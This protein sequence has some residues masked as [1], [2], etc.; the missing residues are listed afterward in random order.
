MPGLNIQNLI[1]SACPAEEAP[2]PDFDWEAKAVVLGGGVMIWLAFGAILPMLPQ[3]DAALSHGP[4]DSLLVKQLFGIVGLSIVIGA[5]LAGFLVDRVGVRVIVVSATLIFCIAGTAG[6]YVN[7]LPL[8]VVSRVLVGASAAAIDTTGITLINACLDGND[9]AKWNG[10]RISFIMASSMLLQPLV[11]AIAEFGW[12]APFALYAVGLPIGLAGALGL[13]K[14]RLVR[15]RVAAAIDETKLWSWF[16]VRYAVLALVLGIC[17]Y[18]P[19]VYGPFLIRETGHSSPVTISLVLMGNSIVGA[20]TAL[21]YGRSRRHLSIDGAFIFCLAWCSA[22][23]LIAA[24]APGFTVL[25]AGFFIGFLGF[26]GISPNLMTAVGESVTRDK[27]GR[28]V[29]LVRSMHELGAPI[30]IVLVQPIATKFGSRGV[31]MTSSL[32][33]LSVLAALVFKIVPRARS[34]Q[35]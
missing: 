3:I 35:H 30:C 13:Q 12:R 25:V 33:A 22:G 2:R 16:P 34:K 11:G 15:E 18:L 9:R 28:A 23:M 6:L 29:G 26:G 17:A 21:L 19:V 1:D 24:L 4:R 27:Q 10:A 8:L 31:L 32:I 5:P 14:G 7:S 20:V